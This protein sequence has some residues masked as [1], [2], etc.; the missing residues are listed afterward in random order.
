MSNNKQQ[1]GVEWL[2]EQIE[3]FGNKHELQMSWTTLDE[4]I[5]QAK[6]MEKEQELRLIKFT[7]EIF[8]LGKSHFSYALITNEEILELYNETN[9][10]NNE[11]NSK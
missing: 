2:A 5:E 6:E 10:T 11:R 3:C 8:E 1:G 9:E 4:L 7:S